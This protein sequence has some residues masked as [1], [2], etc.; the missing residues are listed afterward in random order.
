MNVIFFVR[1]TIQGLS[2]ISVTNEIVCSYHPLPTSNSRMYAQ[3]RDKLYPMYTT[4]H[5][6]HH[7]RLN[8]LRYCSSQLH[9]HFHSSK[10]EMMAFSA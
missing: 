2:Q 9:D 1:L 7:F 3:R 10:L 5:L 6:T 8:D 4:I